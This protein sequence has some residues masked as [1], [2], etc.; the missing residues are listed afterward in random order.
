[1]EMLRVSADDTKPTAYWD[2]ELQKYVISVRRDISVGKDNWYRTIGRCVTS[3]LSDWESE[4][5]EDGCPVVFELDDKD[6]VCHSSADCPGGLDIYTNAWTPYPSPEAPVVHLF[7]PSM[8]YHFGTTPYGFGND[9]LLD[10][11][12]VVSPDGKQLD[13]VPGAPNA[14]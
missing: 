10:I 8:Y 9:G 3:N 12:M 5:G 7:F 2:T 1:M 14:R 4:S 6:P 13:Y 11:R